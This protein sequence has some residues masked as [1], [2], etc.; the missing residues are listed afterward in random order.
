MGREPPTG[1]KCPPGELVPP[2][3]IMMHKKVWCHIIIVESYVEKVQYGLA[4]IP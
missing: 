2:L 4:L 1:G 3:H